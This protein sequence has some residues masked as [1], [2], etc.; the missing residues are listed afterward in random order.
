VSAL[1]LYLLGP[2]RL[3]RDGEPNSFLR[4]FF[5]GLEVGW[6]D[7]AYQKLVEDVRQLTDQ[8]QRLA[9]YRQADRILVEQT[10]IIPLFYQR[11]SILI[12]PLV[13]GHVVSPVGRAFWK[14]VIIEPY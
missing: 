3:E 8:A 6:H 1:A 11:I 9:L 4:V 7:K 13:R 10:P 12:K 14:N 2:P 5:S